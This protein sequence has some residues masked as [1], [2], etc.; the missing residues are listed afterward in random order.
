MA[1]HLNEYQRNS[2]VTLYNIG[3][4]GIKISNHLKINICTVYRWVTRYKKTNTVK[5]IEKSGR[6]RIT[7]E[8]QDNE[9]MKLVKEKGKKFT[10][11]E[12][13]NDLEKINI[14][15]CN[16]TIINRITEHNF[17]SGY[18]FKKPLLTEKHKQ[19]RLQWAI[20]NYDTDWFSVYFSDETTIIKGGTFDK[21]IWI[22]PE[23][24]N[25]KR[26][27][28]HAMKRQLWGC[29]DIRGLVT[30]SI[31]TGN[32]NAERY[33]D[34]L[35]EKFLY[36]YSSE[37]VYQQDNSPI[38]TA[39]ITQKFMK[40]HNIKTIKWPANSPDLNPIENL[41]FLL[42]H[43]LLDDEITTNNFDEKIKVRLEEIKYEHIFNMIA[44]MPIRISKVIQN[45]GDS[46]D[47]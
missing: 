30:Y 41:W 6:K 40:N 38:H 3:W 4:S 9:I 18:P 22:G 21:K 8:D 43:K 17:Y 29:I 14:L 44:S 1:K 45:N 5:E 28:K 33:I 20:E 47:Y 7:T 15:L 19:D 23:T 12:I 11:D 27:V 2:I 37:Y 46:I 36:V 13:R 34:I 10:I 31:F 35:F 16:N 26:T 32:L 42:K 24:V 25:I 39:K